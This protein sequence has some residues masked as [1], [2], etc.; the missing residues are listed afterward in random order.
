MPAL[1]RKLEG[2]FPFGIKAMKAN[3]CLHHKLPDTRG[4]QHTF[5]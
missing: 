5:Q 3:V 2:A 1:S 4:L